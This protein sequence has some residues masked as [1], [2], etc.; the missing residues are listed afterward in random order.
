MSG[1]CRR[2]ANLQ[3]LKSAAKPKLFE[4]LP[5][6]HSPTIE[7]RQVSTKPLRR[8]CAHP[9]TSELTSTGAC[10][11]ECGR[12]GVRAASENRWR[13]HPLISVQGRSSGNG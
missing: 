12:R 9:S 6:R 1:F 8:F 3:A 11:P 10:L 4:L 7:S 5:D 13:S 2:F